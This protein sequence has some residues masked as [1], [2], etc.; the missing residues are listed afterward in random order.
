MGPT[1]RDVVADIMHEEHS[2][3]WPFREEDFR[4]VELALDDLYAG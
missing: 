3:Y 1:L 4:M 2:V